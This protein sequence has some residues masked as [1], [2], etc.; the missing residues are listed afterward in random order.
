MSSLTGGQRKA[1]PGPFPPGLI[2]EEVRPV[3]GSS[4]GGSWQARVHSSRSGW[5]E[6]P[7]CLNIGFIRAPSTCTGLL[8]RQ[9]HFSELDFTFNGT[10]LFWKTLGMVSTRKRKWPS[11]QAKGNSEAASECTGAGPLCWYKPG[12]ICKME[13]CCEVDTKPPDSLT[14]SAQP[15]ESFKRR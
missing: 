4:A 14:P 11:T 8:S 9:R 6:L 7:F 1:A 12:R 3:S 2:R 15:S 13:P 10:D 5:D